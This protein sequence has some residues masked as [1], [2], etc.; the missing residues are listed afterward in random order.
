MITFNDD[1]TITLIL[2]CSKDEYI[3]T[4]KALNNACADLA[5]KDNDGTYLI[6]NLINDMLPDFRQ[7]VNINEAESIERTKAYNKQ[8]V[9][10]FIKQ[11]DLNAV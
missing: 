10:P 1:R 3:N 9:E 11:N 6:N 4:I 7:L 5:E 2:N 8:A